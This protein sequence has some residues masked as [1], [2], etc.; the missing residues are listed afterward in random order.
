MRRFAPAPSVQLYLVLGIL[1]LGSASPSAFA[2]PR[3]GGT[4]GLEQ[5]V[6]VATD[7]AEHRAV[8]RVD[9]GELLLLAPGES[10]E[11]TRAVVEQVLADR[12]VVVETAGA[13]GRR[14]VAWIYLRDRAEGA[15]HIRYLESRAQPTG[16][17]ARPPQGAEQEPP[18][19]SPRV[20]PDD[21]DPRGDG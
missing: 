20:R 14:R 2:S 19:A 7:P 15:P 1:A 9:D 12:I 6:V 18:A 8:L 17:P 13:P 16:S 4:G 5:V 10:I 3:K 11:G 21:R